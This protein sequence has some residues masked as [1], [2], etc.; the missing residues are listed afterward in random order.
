MYLVHVGTIHLHVHVYFAYYRFAESKIH[1]MQYLYKLHVHVGAFTVYT[2]PNQNRSIWDKQ[3][4]FYLHMSLQ[5]EVP[6]TSGYVDSDKK[7]NMFT[8]FLISTIR[9]IILLHSYLLTFL[10]IMKKNCAN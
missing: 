4:F 10:F 1:E 8:C 5:F 2:C 9:C 6:A 7:L 3:L